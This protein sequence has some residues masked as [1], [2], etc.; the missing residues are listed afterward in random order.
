MHD[1]SG[2]GVAGMLDAFGLPLALF[3]AGLVGSLTHCTL[4]CGPFVLAQVAGR[5]EAG[6]AAGGELVRLAGAA[7]VPYH[8]GRM[9]TY[10]VLGGVAGAIAGQVTALTGFA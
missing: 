8:L 5:L 7:L 9:T 10:S 1:H 3:L 4:M 2:A 6:A